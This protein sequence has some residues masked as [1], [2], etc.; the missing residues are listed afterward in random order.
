[1]KKYLKVA[2][3]FALIYSIFVLVSWYAWPTTLINSLIGN[4]KFNIFTLLLASIVVS[5]YFIENNY[6]GYILGKFIKNN[7]ENKAL[8]A[9]LMLNSSFG[10]LM[11]IL[12]TSFIMM[13]GLTTLDISYKSWLAYIWKFVLSMLIVIIIIISIMVYV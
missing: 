3:T 1:M 7:F 13:M 11:T 4:G 12:P 6:S 5:F 8:S 10:T 9:T 2:L